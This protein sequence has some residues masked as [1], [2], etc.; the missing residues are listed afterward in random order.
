MKIYE[1]K[2]ENLLYNQILEHAIQCNLLT[3]R[4]FPRPDIFQQVKTYITS[5]TTTYP[6]VL[7][8]NSGT[9]KSSIMAKLVNEVSAFSIVSYNDLP[10]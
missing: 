7:L 9:G 1:N 2:Q 3:Q 8:G 4:F 10:I 5:S 6:C